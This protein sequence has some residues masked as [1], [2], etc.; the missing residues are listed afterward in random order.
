MKISELKKAAEDTN[1]RN[2]LNTEVDYIF[3][4]VLDTG[5]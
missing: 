3:R 2:I 4:G 5:L 1:Q